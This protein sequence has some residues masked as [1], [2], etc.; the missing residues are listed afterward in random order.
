MTTR[1]KIG[2]LL[3]ISSIQ[4]YFVQIAVAA[5]WNVSPGFSWTDNTIS[6]LGSTVCGQY[7]D[8]FVCSPWHD[9]MNGSLVVLGIT[10]IGGSY[11]LARSLRKKTTT[12]IGFG[13]MMLAGV[14]SLLV[15]VFPENSIAWLHILGAALAFIAGNIG[16]IVIGASLSSLPKWLQIYSI[17]SGSIALGALLLFVNTVYLGLGIGGMERIVAY[18]QSIWMIVVGCYLLIHQRS[19]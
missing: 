19:R 5:A 11:L 9:F 1:I 10:M 13:C 7:G 17:I 12:H 15:G 16:M 2:A 4:Y 3:W 14:G 8:R 6:D 18:P